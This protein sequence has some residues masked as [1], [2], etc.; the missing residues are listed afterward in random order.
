MDERHYVCLDSECTFNLLS[1]NF[2][3][4]HECLLVK[5]E[6]KPVEIKSAFCENCQYTWKT[7]LK[8]AIAGEVVFFEFQIVEKLPW[9]C[10]SGVPYLNIL[11][12]FLDLDAKVC[13]YGMGLNEFNFGGSMNSQCCLMLEIAVTQLRDSVVLFSEYSVTRRRPPLRIITSERK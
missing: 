8:V 4:E 6:C 5:T 12:G 9:D 10:V 7:R 2:M 3:D 13:F 11:E 1:K